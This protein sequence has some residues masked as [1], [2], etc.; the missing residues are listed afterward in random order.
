AATGGRDRRSARRRG[1]NYGRVNPQGADDV[2]FINAIKEDPIL[3]FIFFIFVQLGT[4]HLLD[5][6]V[7]RGVE[8]IELPELTAFKLVERTIHAWK[9]RRHFLPS[10]AA[11]RLAMPSRTDPRQGASNQGRP[12]RL[13]ADR[14]KSFVFARLEPLPR[15]GVLAPRREDGLN[16]AAARERRGLG[17]S[18]PG[19]GKIS[20]ER[21]LT[22]GRL[23]KNLPPPSGE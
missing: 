2:L 19:C 5:H 15:E 9:D 8:M 7:D 18:C 4:K 17:L 22:R 1:S 12:I 11:K 14:I 16:D 6:V 20:G 23:G 10:Y 13:K 21:Q 3:F